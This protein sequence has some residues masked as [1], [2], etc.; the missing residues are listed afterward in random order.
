MEAMYDENIVVRGT[1]AWTAGRV[2]RIIPDEVINEKYLEPLFDRLVAG[3][4]SEPRVAANVCRLRG[5]LI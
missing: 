5:V 3:L 1:A 2:C 4:K